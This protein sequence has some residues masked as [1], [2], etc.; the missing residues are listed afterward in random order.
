MTVYICTVYDQIYFCMHR[1]YALYMTVYICTVHDRVYAPY[2][3]VNL[4][5][6]L[7]K[8]P[9]IYRVGQNPI[10][11]VYV[12]YFWQ[13]NHQIHG[14][15][16]CIYTV[17]ANTIYTPYVCMVL[18]D[19]S[20]VTMCIYTTLLILADQNAYE[21]PCLCHLAIEQVEQMVPLTRPSRPSV[22]CGHRTSRTNGA[23]DS[24]K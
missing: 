4:V 12:R 5:I 1:I 13:G 11:T 7:P 10:Y 24:N 8:I 22:S 6:P 3:T 14:H 17:L 18:A 15:I 21:L 2:M 20:H 23:S 19:P 9:Y 16:R